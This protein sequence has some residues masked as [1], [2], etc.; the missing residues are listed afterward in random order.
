MLGHGLISSPSCCSVD[1]YHHVVD[2]SSSAQCCISAVHSIRVPTLSTDGGPGVWAFWSRATVARTHTH[3]PAPTPVKLWQNKPTPRPCWAGRRLSGRVA[4]H[5]GCR[6]LGGREGEF[7]DADELQRLAALTVHILRT[8][9]DV[10]R[11]SRT[12]FFSC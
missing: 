5:G 8:E 9:Y 7:G 3:R 12:R 2:T 10:R 4:T 11:N 1:Q 6:P